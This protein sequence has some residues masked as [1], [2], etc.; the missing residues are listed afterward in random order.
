M[1]SNLMC[2]YCGRKNFASQRGLHQHQLS[3]KKCFSLMQKAL[4]VAPKI[5]TSKQAVLDIAGKNKNNLGPNLDKF[6]RFSPQEPTF[7][8]PTKANFAPNSSNKRPFTALKLAKT[9]NTQVDSDEDDDNLL[10]R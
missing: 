7:L 1:A 3:N 5:S 2:I 9:N 8:S 10:F 6:T 4:N